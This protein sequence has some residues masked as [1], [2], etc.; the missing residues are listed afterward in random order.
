MVNPL[1]KENPEDKKC[2]SQRERSLWNYK[3]N[4]WNIKKN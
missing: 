2:L 1:V 4:V 3:E